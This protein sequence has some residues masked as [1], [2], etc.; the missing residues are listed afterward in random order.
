M[1]KCFVYLF[2]ATLLTVACSRYPKNVSQ[3]LEL[4]GDNRSE[5]ESVLAHYRNSGESEKFDAACF[6]IGNMTGKGYYAGGIIDVYESLFRKIDSL[7]RSGVSTGIRS[8]ILDTEW[9]HLTK[10]VG[11][12]SPGKTDYYPDVKHVSADLLI[13][14]ID[15]AFM[16][17]DS[18]PRCRQLNQ[19]LFYEYILPYRVRKEMPHDWQTHLY[20][21]MRMLRDTS[22]YSNAKE[23]AALIN[24]YI[25]TYVV[26]NQTLWGY[27][28]DLTVEQIESMGMGGC[29][30]RVLYT[31]MAMRANGIATA[32]DHTPHWA[33]DKGGHYWGVFMDNE[34]HFPFDAAFF[35]FDFIYPRYRK[36]AKA[37]RLSFKQISGEFPVHQDIP[38]RMLER[39]LDVTHEYAAVS[40][41]VIN[42]SD[43]MSDKEYLLIGT[44]NNRNWIPQHAGRIQSD[45]V[46]FKNMGTDIVYIVM[47]YDGG[48][49]ATVGDPFLVDSLGG[50]RYF[51]ADGDRTCDMTLY[52]KFPLVERIENYMNYII[53][54]RFV[55]SNRANLQDTVLLHQI[56]RRPEKFE[57]VVINE[58]RTFRYLR[59]MANRPKQEQVAELEFY[60]LA[61]NGKDTVKLEGKV[62]GYPEPDP[63]SDMNY[64]NVF[65]GNTG[66]YFACDAEKPW[67]GMDFG[68]P[69]RIVKIRYCPRSD[70]NFIEPGDTY[71]LLYWYD[72]DWESL[73]MQVAAKPYLTY[74]NVPSGALYLLR[75]HTKGKEER[76]FTYENGKQIWW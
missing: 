11:A 60:G 33:N 12:P 5:L 26:T 13:A 24:G 71:E 69:R 32:I 44:F 29:P 23:L 39:G 38:T 25:H 51:K 6:L 14:S 56:T 58:P 67:V 16:L 22:V 34:Q 65:D 73:G 59:Y 17:R 53:G 43:D 50:V 76:I 54:G 64:T 52:R 75:N 36:I 2:V 20:R 40:N 1:T 57:T 7:G 35:R 46:E 30:H 3:T 45:K 31:V 37:F 66:N 18:F 55:G 19:S 68:R 49:T 15:H 4:A 21:K 70:T 48:F 10:T 62:I 27:P 28:F 72:N 47:R 9:K 8:S 63:E 42:L 61:D 41:V 74:R